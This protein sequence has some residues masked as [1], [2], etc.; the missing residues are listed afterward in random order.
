MSCY[1]RGTVT[2]LLTS[3][4]PVV[5]IDEIRLIRG[6]IYI[7]KSW[8]LREGEQSNITLFLRKGT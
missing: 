1:I 5:G 3:S 6:T 8:Y 4:I 2:Q 7:H